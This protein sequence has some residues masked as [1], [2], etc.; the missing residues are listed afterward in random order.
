MSASAFNCINANNHLV[1]G[2]QI[3]TPFASYGRPGGDKDLPS[4]FF[5]CRRVFGLFG[6][7]RRVL[8]GWPRARYLPV[9]LQIQSPTLSIWTLGQSMNGMKRH[10][11]Y[12]VVDLTAC[13]DDDHVLSRK[14]LLSPAGDLGRASSG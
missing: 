3:P 11:S 2:P 10:L 13:K 7:S 12:F 5:T 6:S 1:G 4:G 8:A 14:A 9:W